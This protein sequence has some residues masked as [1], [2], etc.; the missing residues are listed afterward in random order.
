MSYFIV[1]RRYDRPK[2]LVPVTGNEGKDDEKLYAFDTEEDAQAWLDNSLV[3][4]CGQFIG[5]IYEA[6]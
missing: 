1:M 2:G 6:P 5:E 4:Q 3:I